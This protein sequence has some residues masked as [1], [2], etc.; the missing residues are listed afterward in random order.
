ND[1]HGRRL[2]MGGVAPEYTFDHVG[3]INDPF[4]GFTLRAAASPRDS[5]IDVN[6]PALSQLWPGHFITLGDRIHQVVNVTSIGEFPNRIRV[7]VMPNIR[8]AQ[9]VGEV[10]IVDQLRLRCRMERG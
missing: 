5:Y 9:P 1:N 8:E 7:S 2:S 3:F 6:K 4:E 10:V